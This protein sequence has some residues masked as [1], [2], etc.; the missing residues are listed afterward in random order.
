VGLNEFNRLF[1]VIVVLFSCYSVFA[2][3][4]VSPGSYS[5]NFH[6]N[7]EYDFE[8]NFLFDEDVETNVYVSGPLS[9]YVQLDTTRLIGGGKVIASL[10]LPKAVES[11]GE[12]K[13]IIGAK[14]V[15]GGIEGINIIADIHGTIRVKVPYPGDYV[16]ADLDV[17][18]ANVKEFAGYRIKISNFGNDTV[19]ISPKIQIFK[20]K[21]LVEVL[22]LEDAQLKIYEETL[23][24]G[25]INTDNYSSGDYDAVAVI[26]YGSE[27]FARA[28]DSFRLGE[29][30]VRILRYTSE[31]ELGRIN[32]FDIEV[33]SFWNN[34]IDALGAE[35]SFVGTGEKL[36]L[37]PIPLDPWG[38][39][40][41]SGFF[42]GNGI[43]PGTRSIEITF[44]HAEGSF[45]QIGQVFVFRKIVPSFYVWVIGGILIFGA[46][47]YRILFLR[48]GLKK[49]K[50]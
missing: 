46:I 15:T 36:T 12:N 42:E 11:Y 40:S 38:K 6:P 3:S 14:E 13:I 27:K 34:P 17:S 31:L 2:F 33:E 45:T 20:E 30:E 49:K 29:F 25:G 41:L 37:P 23:Y 7:L 18:N 8:F 50:S 24:F 10:S 9:E 22:K 44:N 4:G 39:G 35:V 19:K 43:V 1:Y 47:I 28:D 26:E 48:K 16:E 32:K 5:L 21:E